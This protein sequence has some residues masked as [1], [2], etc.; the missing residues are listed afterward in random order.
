M[1]ENIFYI[2]LGLCSIGI[3]FS[4]SNFHSALFL[5]L[6]FITAGTY[7]VES[8]F[9]LFGL[10]LII[11]YA[12]AV[13]TLFLFSAMLINQEEKQSS[14]IFGSLRSILFACSMVLISI[15]I[16]YEVLQND[17]IMFI[18]PKYLI[19]ANSL[20]ENL[21]W[22]FQGIGVI[23]LLAVIGTRIVKSKIQ[24]EK[25]PYQIKPA[26]QISHISK[27]VLVPNKKESR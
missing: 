18:K 8:G 7:I 11:V 25:L 14:L 21:F 16:G 10:I 15:A 13:A 22:P 4:R 9:S 20:Y 26:D 6:S 12:G 2:L 27:V 17:I 24:S 19:M 3:S 5:I 1:I 23:L